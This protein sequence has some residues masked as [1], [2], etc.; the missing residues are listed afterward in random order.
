ML[1]WFKW[2]SRI[3]IFHWNGARGVWFAESPWR[4]IHE[5]ILKLTLAFQAAILQKP[6]QIFI[7]LP[8]A[9]I[10]ADHPNVQSNWERFSNGWIRCSHFLKTHLKTWVLKDRLMKPQ[11]IWLPA[12]KLGKLTKF[13]L[14]RVLFYWDPQSVLKEYR[15][16]QRNFY[17]FLFTE[18][19]FF[20]TN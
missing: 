15:F 9:A 16:D 12:W 7:F 10:I 18:H 1:L 2:Y 3:K 13:S 17:W 19:C 5:P 8:G 14:M 20:L 11:R 4:K 6:T